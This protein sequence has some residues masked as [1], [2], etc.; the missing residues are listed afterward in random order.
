MTSEGNTMKNDT[1]DERREKARRV[2]ENLEPKLVAY[3][4]GLHIAEKDYNMA[5][6]YA[7]LLDSSEMVK[8]YLDDI[9]SPG[10]KLLAQAYISLFDNPLSYEFKKLNI[11][12]LIETCIQED[13]HKEVQKVILSALQEALRKNTEKR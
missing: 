5:V 3:M 10:L 4:N 11:S 6:E 13:H 9:T 2:R 8:D 12:K 1:F 7:L